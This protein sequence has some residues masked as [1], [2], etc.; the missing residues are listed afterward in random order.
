LR[1]SGW[2]SGAQA[3]TASGVEVSVATIQ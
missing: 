3:E 1:N 2:P